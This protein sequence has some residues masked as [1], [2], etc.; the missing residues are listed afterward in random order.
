VATESG[1][2]FAID[3]D[4]FHATLEHDVEIR[5]RIKANLGYRHE[6][7][8]MRL[9]RH[10]SAI[11]RDLLLEYFEPLTAERGT[12]IITEGEKGN[13]FY[14][15]RTGT[16]RVLKQG[17]EVARLG[18]GEAFGETALI[19][20]V[21]RT[22]TVRATRRTELLTLGSEQFHDLLLGYCRREGS[23]ERLSHLRMVAHK[24]SNHEVHR[25]R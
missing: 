19:L 15:I 13:R 25:E 16:V 11:E 10:L 24:R 18:P 21:P 17:S 1:R 23:L 5:D 12:E 20:D 7:A 2:L 3:R 8:G 9:F 14:L 4:S 22:A 6:L